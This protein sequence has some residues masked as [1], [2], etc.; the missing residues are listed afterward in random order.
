MPRPRSNTAALPLPPK[1]SPDL[2]PRYITPE[3]CEL[4][5]DRY[6]SPASRRTIREKWGLK[7]KVVGAR[8]I[9]ETRDF[10]AEAE[11]RLDAARVII[12]ARR[13]SSEQVVA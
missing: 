6:F 11:R 9:T 5:A 7:W 12:G 2:W 3:Q 1:P 8:A 4:I 13:D 10:L